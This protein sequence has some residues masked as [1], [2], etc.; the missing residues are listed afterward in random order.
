MRFDQAARAEEE[1]ADDED[2]GQHARAVFQ[3]P[4]SASDDVLK[5]ARAGMVKWRRE[6]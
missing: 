4:Q 3:D 5:P 6:H 2:D 1:S